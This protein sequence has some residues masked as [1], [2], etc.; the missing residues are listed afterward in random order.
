MF[1]PF[2]I[3]TALELTFSGAGTFDINRRYDRS[4][5]GR[6]ATR[7]RP[8]LQ[9]SARGANSSVGPRSRGIDADIPD[10]Y[11]AGVQP[12]LGVM[13]L[14]GI[15]VRVR[16]SDVERAQAN[17]GGGDSGR[18]TANLAARRL[19]NPPRAAYKTAY[20]TCPPGR[21]AGWLRRC[22]TQRAGTGH[23]ALRAD[24]PD[25]RDRRHLLLQAEGRGRRHRR[26][27]RRLRQDLH[28]REGRGGRHPQRRRRALQDLGRRWPRDKY[29]KV[30]PYI[31]QTVEITGTEVT[32][33][34]NYDVRSF[35][36]QTVKRKGK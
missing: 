3:S 34:N 8:E 20:E 28:P 15:R 31:G 19:Y 21:A 23:Q 24:D 29:A 13:R 9:L 36:L 17:A 10:A 4:A 1:V 7:D 6:R 32:L 33:S 11:M 30:L 12:A 25:R 22:G 35:D 2:W 18:I 14:G 26:R 5:H 16:S 27:A